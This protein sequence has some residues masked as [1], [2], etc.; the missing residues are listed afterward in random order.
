MGAAGIVAAGTSNL[1]LDQVKD[2][3]FSQIDMMNAD[4]TNNAQEN[5]ALL[6]DL[7]TRLHHEREDL[8]ETKEQL[9][10]QMV[11]FDSSNQVI[12]ARNN[13]IEILLK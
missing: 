10:A 6:N 2:K 12:V 11:E 13:Q 5:L 8:L 1:E 3:V 9:S 4:L 7:K